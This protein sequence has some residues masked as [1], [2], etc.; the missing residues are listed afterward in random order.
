MSTTITRRA[1]GRLTFCSDTGRYEIGRWELHCGNCFQVKLDDGR[2]VDTR[3]EMGCRQW[4]LIGVP[5]YQRL[6]GRE[7][8][9]HD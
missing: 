6:E 3:I 4:Y 7:A 1:E 5:N 8:R 2:W 9:S